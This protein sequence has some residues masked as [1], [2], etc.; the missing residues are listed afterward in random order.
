MTQYRCKIA[1][2]AR[3]MVFDAPNALGRCS[4]AFRERLEGGPGTLLDVSW[5]LLARPGRLKIS[6][7]A[8]FVRPQGVPSA[9]GRVPETVMSTQSGPTL[10]FCRFLIDLAKIFIDFS[11]I[12]RLQFAHFGRCLSCFCPRRS[13]V[14]GL[15]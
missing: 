4:G 1:P 9:S 15:R 2:Q 13:C 8:T 12:F 3:S 7:W 11:S 5:P 14:P 10:N 6:L